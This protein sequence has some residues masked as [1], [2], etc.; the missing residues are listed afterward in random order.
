[1]AR[2]CELVVLVTCLVLA[3]TACQVRDDEG[4]DKAECAELVDHMVSLEFSGADRSSDAAELARHRAAMTAAIKDRVIA[5]CLA[6]P[7][8]Y[9][10]CALAA[11]TSREIGA[12]Q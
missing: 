12:C 6:R 3:S 8:A 10:E 4:S 9:S 5:D 11:R 7:R 2:I 1:M